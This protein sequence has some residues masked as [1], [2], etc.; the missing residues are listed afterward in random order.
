MDC[1]IL[2]APDGAFFIIMPLFLVVNAEKGKEK[3]I[4]QKVK[5]FPHIS[6]LILIDQN[7]QGDVL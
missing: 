3:E 2:S 4:I 6:V 1:I 7:R 5:N